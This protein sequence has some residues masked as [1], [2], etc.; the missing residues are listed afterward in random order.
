MNYQYPPLDEEYEFQ[1]FLKDFFNCHFQTDSFEN[2]RTK[3]ASQYG[4][5][6]YSPT[7]Q[8]AVQAKKKKLSR[9]EPVLIRELL[10]DLEETITEIQ[11]FPFP[12]TRAI[13][14]STTKKFSAVQDECIRYSQ[15]S[16][17]P[18]QFWSWD[19][20]QK[21][22][23]GC[24]SLQKKYYPNFSLPPIPKELIPMARLEV[25]QI[26]GREEDLE[27]IGKRLTD[28]RILCLQSM[29]GVGKT[30]MC[31][32]FYQ[33]N[34]VAYDHLLWLDHVTDLKKDIAFHSS[35]QISLRLE[36]L[37]EDLLEKRYH[38]VLTALLALPGKILIVI[39]NLHHQE[40]GSVENEVRK[41]LAKKDLHILITSRQAFRS[42]PIYEL[43]NLTVP[44]ANQ[45]FDLHCP[46]QIDRSNLERLLKVVSRNALLTELTAK[47]IYNGVG[48]MVDDMI[49]RFEEGDT[50]AEELDI[51]IEKV[52]GNDII[53]ARL[54]QQIAKIFNLGELKDDY[55]AY[56]VLCLSLLPSIPIPITEVIEFYLY[57]EKSL[58]PIINSINE[59]HK[60]GLL[61][62]SGDDVTMHHLIQDVVRMQ[63]PDYLVYIGILNSL[64]R[65]LDKANKIF[66]QK[67][68]K[69]QQH[70]EAA[71]FKLKG[72]KAKS[73]QQPLTMLKNNLFIALRYLGEKEKAQ[74][75]GKQLLEALPE[76]EE[77]GYRDKQFL[78]TLYHN[79]ATF[80]NDQNNTDEAEKYL[81]KAVET[82]G[83]KF[84]PN[85]IHFYNAL[86]TIYYEQGRS[87]E[88]L[89]CCE[90]ALEL[91]QKPEAKGYDHLLAM[92]TNNLA[93]ANL[94]FGSLENAATYILHAI[95][96]H[97]MADS[98]EKNPAALAAYYS[99][100]ALIY[101]L[102]KN[103]EMAIQ[104][105]LHAIE[106]QASLHLENDEAL[107]GHYEMAARVYESAGD[108]EK[109]NEL[110]KFIEGT[111]MVSNQR[112]ES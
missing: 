81:K 76:M 68:Y 70:A 27:E 71:L 46:K 74:Q 90:K 31:K 4:I 51:D 35:L 48:L 2:Y 112:S 18:I 75:M 12:V 72:R 16:T 25:D 100:A 1:E 23:A 96:I 86:Y 94:K 49:V 40:G 30:T 53:N 78:A 20:I 93:M 101:S 45:L 63:A 64:L 58:T 19:D 5:D 29:G 32:Y 91:L 17:V 88:A 85:T 8:I 104:F 69:L 111:Q 9:S 50:E 108:V 38:I 99:N 13:L 37:P 14:A 80:Y 43:P 62:R 41:L 110:R 24:I 33:H 97:R 61:V 87:Q 6:V 77:M 105:A 83:C 21:E 11:D 55:Q 82:I 44:A 102:A 7:L 92:V 28:K 66:S 56:L 67:G 109:A 39:D 15:N 42:F 98:D 54:H 10:N 103:H 89:A 60:R 34:E 52:D 36:E 107:V 106:Y 26:L 3:G 84:T 22:I 79:I 95:K 47:T 65:S 73:V 57:S 59:L